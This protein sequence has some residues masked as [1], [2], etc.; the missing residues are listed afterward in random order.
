VA[1][2]GCVY[3]PSDIPF[4]YHQ[5]FTDAANGGNPTPYVK[6]YSALQADLNAGTLPS[7]SFVKPRAFR[8]EHPNVS[9]I[10]DGV[11]FVKSM[12]D[13]ILSSASYGNN[14]LVL[15]TWDE[16][17][18]FYDHVAPP[19]SPPTAVDSDDNG[20]AV[21]YGTRV[22]LL[23]IGPFSK[24]GTVSHAVLEHSS[25]VKFLE[26]N[27]LTQTGQLGA[28]DGWVQNIG[29]LLDPNATGIP[30]PEK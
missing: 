8:N 26:W 18:G 25:V 16:G 4:L 28:R 20:A 6:D 11:A 12:V 7:F 22:P 3:D 19:A 5:R 17:G 13:M 24:K 27:F 21:P 30:V 14:T 1:C 29:S 2:H 15:L 9:T 23:A 10:A